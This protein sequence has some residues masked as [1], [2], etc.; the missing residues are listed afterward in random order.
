LDSYLYI[1][2]GQVSQFVD[3]YNDTIVYRVN[4]TLSIPLDKSWTNSTVTFQSIN[5]GSY[6]PVDYPGLWTNPISK[7]I[8]SWGGNDTTS[9]TNKHLWVFVPDGNGGGTWS[10]QEP[11]NPGVIRTAG[12]AAA[13]CGMT[14]FYLGGFGDEATDEVFASIQSISTDFGPPG[15]LAFDMTT[16]TWSNETSLPFGAA[17]GVYQF[18]QAVCVPT[19]GSNG[20]L[21]ILGG[22]T[23][24]GLS[25]YQG[26]TTPTLYVP[27][28][29]LTFYD[30]AA[31]NWYWQ[32]TTGDS[33]RTRA[34]F[35]AVGIAGPNQTYEM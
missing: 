15:L 12:G 29:N 8:Y 26:P 3:G 25:T 23:I 16:R 6:P 17:S 4:K 30:P 20:L 5:K 35:C 9:A 14:G 18:G 7:E 22:E 24:L 28:N 19:F 21:M 1:E 32:M 27:L 31:K 11:A 10:I 13:T 2:G 34:F 33:P